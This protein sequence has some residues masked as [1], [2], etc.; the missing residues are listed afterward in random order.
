[1]TLP[2]GLQSG[3]IQDIPMPL[4]RAFLIQW[5]QSLLQLLDAIERELQISPRTAELR[6]NSKLKRNIELTM[7]L[8]MQAEQ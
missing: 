4:P 5:R 6:R 8:T 7:E 2:D 3:I 1:M